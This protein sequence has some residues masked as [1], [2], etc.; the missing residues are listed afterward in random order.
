MRCRLSRL[1]RSARRGVLQGRQWGGDG[2]DRLTVEPLR[3]AAIRGRRRIRGQGDVHVGDHERAALRGRRRLPQPDAAVVGDVVPG[4]QAQ[5]AQLLADVLGGGA[6]TD[7]IRRATRPSDA[8]ADPFLD[9]VPALR[10]EREQLTLASAGEPGRGPGCRSSARLATLDQAIDQAPGDALGLDTDLRQ[11][12]LHTAVTRRNAVRQLIRS[13]NGTILRWTLTDFLSPPVSMDAPIAAAF[14]Q[15][16]LAR[17]LGEPAGS[18]A[19][20]VDFVTSGFRA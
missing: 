13:M 2:G 20:F 17:P 1:L 9:P 19:D 15:R 5:I 11:G 3:I 7:R 12:L 8:L 6:Q 14:R 4:G 16:E 18:R 10:D